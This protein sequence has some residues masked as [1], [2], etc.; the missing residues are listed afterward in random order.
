M[1]HYLKAVKASGT[2][3]NEAVVATMRS[4]PVDDVFAHGGRIRADGIMTHD[5]YLMQVK[6]IGSHQDPSDMYDV[7]KTIPPQD[8]YRP[9][10]KSECPLVKT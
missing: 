1:L 5:F 9:L 2:T 7:L 10:A 4:T 8:A 3:E 6:A